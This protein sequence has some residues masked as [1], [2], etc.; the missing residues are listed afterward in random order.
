MQ[1]GAERGSPQAIPRLPIRN[2]NNGASRPLAPQ[3]FQGKDGIIGVAISRP[4]PAPQWPLAGPIASPTSSDGSEPYRPPPGKSQPPQRP[5]RPS[6]V[7]S[8]LDSSRI[9]DHTPVFQYTPQNN[10]ASELSIPDTPATQTSSRPTTQ[11]SVGSIPDFPVPEAAPPFP[12]PPLPPVPRRSVTLGPP[13]SSRRGNSAFYSTASYVSP[14]PEES[15][16]SRSHGSY[17]SSAAIP[18]SFGTLSPGM[19]AGL[20]PGTSDD[21]NYFDDTI[22]E[23][24]VYSDDADESDLVRSASIGRKGKPSL[25]TTRSSERGEMVP[26]VLPMRPWP[27]PTQSSPFSDGTGYIEESPNSSGAPSSGKVPAVNVT[28][29][30]DTT[31]G[32]YNVATATDALAL[33]NATSSP[34]PLGMSGLR[35][36]PKLDIDAVR[37]AEA[38]GSLTSLPDLIRRATRLAAMMDKGKR[39]ASRF[40]MDYAEDAEKNYSC[41]LY[42]PVSVIYQLTHVIQMTPRSTNPG[43]PTCLPPSPLQR[44]PEPAE[45]YGKV[46]CGKVTRPLGHWGSA[47][48]KRPC[49]LGPCRKYH[50]IRSHLSLASGRSQ[51]ADAADY[52]CGA[53]WCYYLS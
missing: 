49:G 37:S 12:P 51:D 35:R 53:S 22:A 11:S 28:S 50:W 30:A 43:S 1:R 9:Q 47:T 45:V 10:R 19:T 7:P 48:A 27:R 17:A 39:P 13:P 46:F 4:T 18:D 36:P 32:V 40:D 52:R 34:K 38:R 2:P 14:I 8:M 15:P 33:R 25:V 44:R 29:T 3:A 6:R 31:P 26:I 20:S 21:D 24:S 42:F 16:R 5:P 23:E 41:M